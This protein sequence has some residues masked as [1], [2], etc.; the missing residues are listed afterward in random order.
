MIVLIP[1]ISFLIAD[2]L[3]EANFEQGWVIIPRDLLGPAGMPIDNLYLQLIATT[4]VAVA[5]FGGYTIIYMVI[6]STMG[7]PRYGPLDVP[8][9]K[10]KPIKKRRGA[11][12][13]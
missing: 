8:P 10:R 12:R 2:L 11:G 13:R 6:Y 1:I 5:L 9:L 7:P 4:L 3:V